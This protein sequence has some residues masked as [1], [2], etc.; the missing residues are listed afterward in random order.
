MK[1][2]AYASVAVAG[3]AIFGLTACGDETTNNNYATVAIEDYTLKTLPKCDST[4]EG[5]IGF[6][7]TTEE[8]MYCMD[9]EWMNLNGADGDKGDKGKQGE[10]GNAGDDCTAKQ[11]K[12]K[13]GY[14]IVCGEDSVG[15]VLNGEKGDKGEQGE[16]GESCKMT[17][18]TDMGDTVAMVTCKKDTVWLM[19]GKNVESSGSGEGTG[20][21]EGSG[22]GEGTGSGEG[23]GSG[24]GPE[25]Q[26][27]TLTEGSLPNGL[28]IIG[29]QVWAGQNVNDA[30]KGGTCYNNDEEYCETFGR[31]Y[32]WSE[33]MDEHLSNN[34]VSIG[35]IKKNYQGICPDGY[36]I[37]TG[38]DWENLSKY[39]N[40]T[41]RAAEIRTANDYY[42]EDDVSGIML[43]GTT[44]DG[45]DMPIWSTNGGVQAEDT[46][47]FMVVGAGYG[48]LSYDV[49]DE[50]NKYE[51]VFKDFNELLNSAHFWIAAEESGWEA[52]YAYRAAFDVSEKAISIDTDSKMYAFSVRCIMNMSAQDYMKTD[53]YKKQ[54]ETPETPAAGN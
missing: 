48:E 3:L 1:H 18:V 11:L 32:T 24:E 21:G 5:Q 46:Y 36:H 49:N 35:T 2:I 10:K 9:G 54:F 41:K 53:E 8:L 31:L 27:T 6:V 15:V 20:S 45:N 30:S 16:A 52:S 40:S 19:N 17:K 7:T 39:V 13:S 25:N 12:D 50:T 4:M 28:V 23:S 47:G 51:P 38:T 22:S 34:D 37:P 43:R 14:K 42:D 33:A 29:N 44:Y 26:Q